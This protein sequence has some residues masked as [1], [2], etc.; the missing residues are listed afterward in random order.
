MRADM[1]KKIFVV[2]H[3]FEDIDGYIVKN[4]EEH[5]DNYTDAIEHFD[6]LRNSCHCSFILIYTKG[7]KN[8]KNRTEDQD[9]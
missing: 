6:F 2:K 3:D 1:R 5:F 7:A 9:G 4:I 8:E